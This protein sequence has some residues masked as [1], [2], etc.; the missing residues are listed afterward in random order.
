M[1]FLKL[2]SHLIHIELV[3]CC[4]ELSRH[5]EQLRTIPFRILAIF[6]GLQMETCKHFW[7][8]KWVSKSNKPSYCSFSSLFKTLILCF[9]H[10]KIFRLVEVVV[11]YLNLQCSWTC[12]LYWTCLFCSGVTLHIFFPFELLYLRLFQRYL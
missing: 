5:M 12:V 8:G 11:L 2:V 4:P 9:S 3:A 7:G 6:K 10:S 1:N